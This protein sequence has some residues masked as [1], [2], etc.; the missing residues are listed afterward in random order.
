MTFLKI[1][2]S[3][4]AYWCILS[5]EEGQVDAAVERWLSSAGTVDSL[6]DLTMV[7]GENLRVRASRIIGW[8]RSTPAG[9]AK[10]AEVEKQ[11]EDERK[12]NRA[13]AGLFDAED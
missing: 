2:D 11:M 9:R 7:D 10:G 12:A 4:G 6:L 1:Y 5:T 3:D 13:A 8:T